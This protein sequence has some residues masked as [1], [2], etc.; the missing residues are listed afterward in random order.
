[1]D[2][3]PADAAAS[4]RHTRTRGILKSC[5]RSWRS[6][7]PPSVGASSTAVVQVRMEDPIYD[8]VAEENYA[9]LVARRRE[10][11][12]TFIIDDDV[13]GYVDDSREEDSTHRALPSPSDEGSGGEDGAPRKRTARWVVAVVAAS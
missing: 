10:D 2:D 1:M 7:P 9:A 8:V 6:A 5:W 4:G 13:L 12:D 3:A 11:A